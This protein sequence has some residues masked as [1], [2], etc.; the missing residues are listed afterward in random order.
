MDAKKESF[1]QIPV[2]VNCTGTSLGTNPP[3]H[4]HNGHG[5][6]SNSIERYRLPPTR[7]TMCL[8]TFIYRYQ[9]GLG[10]GDENIFLNVSNG[11]AAAARMS[12]V[13]ASV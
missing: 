8:M 7:A 11:P 2:V 12:C 13:A 1:L 3:R 5:E 9:S 4:T 10:V 6:I